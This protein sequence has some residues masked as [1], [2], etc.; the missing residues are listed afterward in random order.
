MVM[1]M[2]WTPH[3]PFF[4]I[5]FPPNTFPTL[6]FG[7]FISEVTVKTFLNSSPGMRRAGSTRLSLALL[8]EHD[9]SSI[10]SLSVSIDMDDNS[11]NGTSVQFRALTTSMQVSFR[12][13]EN[14]W[15]E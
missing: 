5:S 9:F 14:D 10:P 12:G 1:M 4:K 2:K 11:C 6:S 3:D 8:M 13:R 15:S 7:G